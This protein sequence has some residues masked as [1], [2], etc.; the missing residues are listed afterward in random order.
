[1]HQ[2]IMEDLGAYEEYPISYVVAF[3]LLL[4]H[5]V[6][7]FSY[8]SPLIFFAFVKV[9]NSLRKRPHIISHRGRAS[10]LTIIVHLYSNTMLV[11]SIWD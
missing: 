1:M 5:H 8:L 2:T 6:S 10:L 3:I 11:L 4:L 7:C 9:V